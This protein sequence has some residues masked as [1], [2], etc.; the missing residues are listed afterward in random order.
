MKTRA[1]Y[2]G[3]FDPITFGHLDVIKRGA[4]LFDE[5]VVAVASNP[6]KESF[7]SVEERLEMV[8]QSV[9]GMK[10]VQVKTF[11]S[12]LV[13]FAKKEK[14]GVVIRGLREM[15]DF[16]GEFQQALVNRKL[17][18][19]LETVFVVTGS[20][21]FYLSSSVVKEL[22]RFG[23]SVSDFVPSHVEKKLRGLAKKNS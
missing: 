23:G 10:N 14:A 13:D 1:V 17:A 12:L 2:P 3:T 9:K 11:D 7:F 6:P 16:P 18:P 4:K 22:S 21:F 15:S 20:E 8:G 19:N 5:L